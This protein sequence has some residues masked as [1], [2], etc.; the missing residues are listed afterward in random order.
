MALLFLNQSTRTRLSFFSALND[1]GMR[2]LYLNPKDI[3]HDDG[4]SLQDTALSISQFVDVIGLRLTEYPLG[5]PSYPL[6]NQYFQTFAAASECPV[7]NME[8]DTFHPCQGLA[9]LK[10]LL[11]LQVPLPKITISWAYSP[12]ALRVPAIPIE[13]M[14]LL[15]RFFKQ[16]VLACPE[17]FMLED[18]FI[19]IAQHYAA[20]NNGEI[21]IT[22]DFKAGI[23]NSHVIYARN[24]VSA[25]VSQH[26]LEAEKKLHNKY[27][28]WHVTQSTLKQ[29]AENIRYMHCMP[30]HRSYEA[31]DRV[32]DGGQSLI[33]TQ[34]RNR[35]VVQKAL[36]RLVLGQ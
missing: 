30:I 35:S 7:I 14:T 18:K 24:W 9:D 10:T 31:E 3:R 2:Y 25:Q 5:T 19:K 11:D 6:A 28:D 4:E 20:Q 21:V 12:S 27:K 16:V 13:L 32:I 29:G 8:C 17:A 33:K 36:L 34:M 26:G 1:L 15:P 22:H 23:A